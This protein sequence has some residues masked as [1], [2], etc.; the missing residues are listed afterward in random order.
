MKR[1]AKKPKTKPV[2]RSE[3][4]RVK[5]A[6]ALI[7][8]RCWMNIG[9]DDVTRICEMLFEQPTQPKNTSEARSK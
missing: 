7:A 1:T 5:D 6:V 9:M 2:T 4:D 3:M 8:H